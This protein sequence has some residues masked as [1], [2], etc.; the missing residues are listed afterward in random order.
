VQQPTLARLSTPLAPRDFLLRLPHNSAAHTPLANRGIHSA[1]AALPQ[2][3]PL[4]SGALAQRLQRTL[5]ALA[6]WWAPSLPS[7]PC[8]PTGAQL[9][10]LPCS[11]TIQRAHPQH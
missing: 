3:L 11:S 2:Q 7:A 9:A 4:Q 5:S 6:N 8:R 10:P 1:Y